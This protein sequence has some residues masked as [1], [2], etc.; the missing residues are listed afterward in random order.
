MPAKTLVNGRDLVVIGTSAG[1]LEAVSKL[2][3]QLPSDLPA[4]IFVVQH[5]APELSG[6]ALLHRLSKYKS[7]DARFGKNGE[8][9][10]RGQI[11][12]APPDYHMLVREKTILV[13][14]GARENGFRP[15]V[16]PLFRSAAVTHGNRV[17]G[18]ILTG[19]LDD[20]TAGMI[21]VKRCGGVTIVQEP[22]D[23]SYPSMPQNALDHATVDHRAPVS[24][25]GALLDTLTRQRPG[26]KT[27]VPA[28]IQVEAEIAERVLSDVEAVNALG[29][30][31]PYNCPDCGGPLWG[32]KQGKLLRYRCHVGHSFTAQ[33]LLSMQSEKIEETLW[34]ALRM[35]EERKNLL[36]NMI[37]NSPTG[38]ISKMTMKRAAEA[39]EHIDRIRATLMAKT[40]TN[41]A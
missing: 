4:A 11:Y 1:G 16:D 26:K 36:A 33:T 17:I 6:V 34:V 8:A 22:N 7:F 13:T 21:A 41:D 28:D 24:E 38:A 10:K 39:Q 27:P 5:L 35:F 30:Q 25:M 32:M 12:V 19:M 3:A 29:P 20:G 37:K 15:A 14:K 23:A 9:I 40:S 2:V 31:V 18:I